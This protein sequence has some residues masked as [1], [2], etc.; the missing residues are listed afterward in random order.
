MR[1]LILALASLVL[2]A[3]ATL[4]VAPAQPRVD[5]ITTFTLAGVTPLR[6]TWDFGDRTQPQ[7][8]G[9]VATHAY[10]QPGTYLARCTYMLNATTGTT[11]SVQRS[12]RVVEPRR[13]VFSPAAPE[14]GQPVTF[15]ALNFFNDK[16]ISWSFGDDSSAPGATATHTYARKGTYTVSVWDRNANGAGRSFQTQ[17]TVGNTGPGAA[18]SLSYLALRWEDGTAYKTVTQGELGLMAYAD[19]KFEGAG[20]LQAQWMVDGVPFR[21][22]TRQLAFAGRATLTSGQDQP[23][24]P[25]LSF[26]TNLPGEH[27][28]TLLVTTPTLAFEVPV[29]RYYVRLGTDPEGPAT[30]SAFPSRTRAGEEVEL[31][32]SGDRFVAGMVPEFGRDIAVVGPLR[33]LNP[34]TAVVKVFVAPSA[35]PGSRIVRV[36]KPGGGPAGN[37]R[38]TVLAPVKKPVSAK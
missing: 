13:I 38:I 20:M 30:R 17:V 4:D 22:V 16:E 6:A 28:V 14:P 26:P 11:A 12:V 33:V 36:A 25:R 5:G 10:T 19:L 29:L 3:Q 34:Q 8:G 23:T 2:Q 35:R 1:A 24:A 37:A 7:E 21:T 31:Q 9:A 27:R 18:F 15:R 32:L